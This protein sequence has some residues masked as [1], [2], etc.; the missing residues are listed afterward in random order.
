MNE[1]KIREG[2]KA[3]ILGAYSEAQQRTMLICPER[4]TTAQIK[5]LTCVVELCTRRSREL[6][7]MGADD[8]SMDAVGL[9]FIEAK[10]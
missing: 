9:E 8:W 1:M 2:C 10:P 7:E 6:I 5:H 4:Y 3:T